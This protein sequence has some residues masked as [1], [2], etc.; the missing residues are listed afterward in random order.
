MP[1]PRRHSLGAGGGV[2]SP[3]FNVARG[4]LAESLPSVGDLESRWLYPNCCQVTSGRTFVARWLM[5]LSA[6]FVFLV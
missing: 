5:R 2:P 4:P 3:C 1:L 6:C